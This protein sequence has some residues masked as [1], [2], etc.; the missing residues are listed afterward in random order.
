MW[1]T[2]CSVDWLF[3]WLI[4][5]LIQSFMQWFLDSLI[6]WVTASLIDWLIDWLICWLTH[7]FLDGLVGLLVDSSLVDSSLVDSF[8]VDLF[9]CWLLFFLIHCSLFDGFN[10]SVFMWFLILIRWF[11][12]SLNNLCEVSF[13]SVR[14]HLSHHLVIRWCFSQ[15]QQLIDS[16]SPKKLINEW[17]SFYNWF[18]N[19]RSFRPCAGRA[20][21]NMLYII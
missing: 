21:S 7:W 1:S 2:H 12:D 18:E 4:G 15:I 9:V 10:D 11:I 14:W 6:R 3:Q 13:M 17:L 8:L 16:A 19:F 5:S 20:L